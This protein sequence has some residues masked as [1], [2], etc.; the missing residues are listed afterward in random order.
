MKGLSPRKVRELREQNWLTQQELADA[1][2]VSL[3][4]VQR[5][6]RGDGGVRP[7][8]ARATARV[9]GVTVDDLT[10]EP[11]LTAPKA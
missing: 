8:T 7:A 4:T 10:E 9:L 3:Y 6:E 2:G 1:V 11:A 5:M